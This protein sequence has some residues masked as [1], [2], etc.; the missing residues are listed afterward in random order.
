MAWFF[1]S[2]K[3]H[4]NAKKD[5]VPCESKRKGKGKLQ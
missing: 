1:G 2:R 3:L 5:M 4:K